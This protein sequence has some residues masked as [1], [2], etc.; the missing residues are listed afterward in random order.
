MFG[1][2]GFGLLVNNQRLDLSQ[3]TSLKLS[4]LNN[5]EACLDLIQNLIICQGGPNITE[6]SDT[7]TECAVKDNGYWR[8]KK[9][10]LLYLNQRKVPNCEYCSELRHR[11]RQASIRQATIKNPARIRVTGTNET[12][13]RRKRSSKIQEK[14]RNATKRVKRKEIRLKALQDELAN[15]HNKMKNVCLDDILNQLKQNKV[16]DEQ[17]YLAVL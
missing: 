5:L 16:P 1:K 9:C 4:S 7:Y 17:V 13:R 3:F 2:N 8:H 10:P 6:Y 15:C 14:F 11:L 12:P